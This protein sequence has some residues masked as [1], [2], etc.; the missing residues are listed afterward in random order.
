MSGLMSTASDLVFGGGGDGYF[1]ALDAADGDELW[2]MNIGGRVKAA[3]ITYMAGG[4]QLVLIAAGNA[5]FTFS[6]R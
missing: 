1:Y 6:L 5:I 2:R 3:P 4:E